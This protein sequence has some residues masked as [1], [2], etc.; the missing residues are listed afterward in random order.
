MTIASGIFKQLRFKKETTWGVAAGTTGGQ[1]LRRV[2]SDLDLLKSTYE[3][4]EMRSDFQVADMRHGIR[5]AAGTINGELSPGTYSEFFE[6]ALRKLFAAGA[7]TGVK[8]DISFAANAINRGAGSFITDGF[9]VGDVVRATGSAANS[10]KNC[11]ITTLTALAMGVDRTLTV[12]AVGPSVTVALPGKKT[13]VP[14]TGHTDDSFSIEHF[15]ADLVQ[16][17][18]FTGCKPS[19]IDVDLPPT[20]MSTI[21]INVQ[22]KGI[23][24]DTSE[25]FTTPSSET[26]SGLLTGVSGKLR[27]GTTD[28]AV[29]TGA[30][31]SIQGNYSNAEVVGSNEIAAVFPGRVRVSGEFTAYF[32]DVT[33]R[34][35]FVNETELSLYLYLT[36]GS[37]DNAD[38]VN[39]IMPRIKVGG[40][41]KDDGEKG[42][43]QT[44]PF[45]ALLNISG[46]SAVN[47]EKTTISIQDSLA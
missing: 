11:R 10:N 3:S 1:L 17:E 42:I 41:K 27:V 13:S 5:S 43:I 6:A 23:T 40:A 26:T 46:G 36:T 4:N 45:T 8:T 20:G 9:K 39:I 21:A 34:D 15:F 37:E 22:G 33:L 30:K 25:Y 44:I 35:A 47:S 19:Q 28:L 31:L 29:V 32:E 12:E 14:L 7:T 16:S 18:L 24:P 38:F 2:T